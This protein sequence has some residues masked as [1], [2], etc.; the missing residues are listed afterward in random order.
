MVSF[1]MFKRTTPSL[2]IIR[3]MPFQLEFKIYLKTV[4]LLNLAYVHAHVVMQQSVGIKYD[5]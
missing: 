1:K 4:V 5:K 2:Q 3:S